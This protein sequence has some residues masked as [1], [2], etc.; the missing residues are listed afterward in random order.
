MYDESQKES[1]LGD[2][3]IASE[4][5]DHL[6]AGIDTTA[7]SLTFLI[8]ALSRPQHREIQ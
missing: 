7:D 3:D 5:A 8:W 2:L 6:L 1:G 4:C